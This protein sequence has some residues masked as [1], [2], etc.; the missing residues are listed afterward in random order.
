MFGGT[1]EFH[2]ES[3]LDSEFHFS[4]SDI[5]NSIKDN[6]ELINVVQSLREAISKAVAKVMAEELNKI[7]E[8][9]DKIEGG[10][11]RM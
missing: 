8:R 4:I 1:S 6:Q 10:L 3:Q 5:T 9:L 2:I 11:R 7:Y